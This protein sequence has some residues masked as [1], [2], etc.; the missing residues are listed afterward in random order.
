MDSC[1]GSEIFLLG[2]GVLNVHSAPAPAK[3][4]IPKEK[5]HVFTGK[6]VDRCTIPCNI[7]VNCKTFAILNG[8]AQN[9]AQFT[10]HNVS[11]PLT[12]ITMV[13][14]WNLCSYTLA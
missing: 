2:G 8:N 3:N 14:L 7:N 5:K 11:A 13:E 10:R 12:L 9:A 6:G 1:K 4:E